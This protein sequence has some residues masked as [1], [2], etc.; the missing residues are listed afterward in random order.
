MTSYAADIRPLFSDLDVQG[1]S[2]AF[3]LRSYD[4]CKAHAQ[5]MYDRVRGIGNLMPPLPP[6]GDGPW[7]QERIDLFGKWV[8]EGCPP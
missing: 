3:D 6:R 2:R 1:M 4:A 5:A 8:A 7:S